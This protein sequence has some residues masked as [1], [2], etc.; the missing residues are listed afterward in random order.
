MPSSLVETKL[1]AKMEF[2]TPRPNLKCGVKGHLYLYEGHDRHMS[3]CCCKAF[4]NYPLQGGP[5]SCFPIGR[6]D[7]LLTLFTSEQ[8]AAI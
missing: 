5:M 8:L 3:P 1:P 6:L 2:P 4:T 7:A